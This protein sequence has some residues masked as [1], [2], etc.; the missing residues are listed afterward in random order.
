[1]VEEMY[2]NL[3]SIRYIF[4][5]DSQDFIVSAFPEYSIFIKNFI[6]NDQILRS[7]KVANYVFNIPYVSYSVFL[8]NQILTVIIPIINHGLKLGTIH[9]GITASLNI[10]FMFKLIQY[11]SL[12][13]FLSVWGTVII[14]M[15]FIIISL[16]K[17]FY[18]LWIGM[19]N[20]G[21]GN[22]AQRIHAPVQGYFADL[23]IGF[24]EMAEKLEFYEKKNIEQLILEK[25]KL[26]TLISI[27]ADGAIL[28]D[29][30]LRIIFINQSA[31]KTLELVKHGIVGTYIYDH[32]PHYINEQF[33]PVLNQM[34]EK[35]NVYRSFA[36]TQCLLLKFNNQVSKT[37]R[38][39]LTT[40]FDKKLVLTG[41]AVIIEDI[42]SEIVLNEAKA[43]FISNVSHELRTPLFNIKSF[44][45]TL[46]EYN[47]YLSDIQKKD[48]LEI[49]SQETQRLT[50]LVND[51]L[52]LSRLESDFQYVSD[53][54]LLTDMIPSIIQISQLRAKK[55]QIVLS[56]KICS[57]IVKV[58]AYH[59]L[60]MQVLSNLL[61]N[62][63]KF[64]Y[65]GGR[66]II[67][68]HKI[69]TSTI[70]SDNY[71]IDKV[72][73]QIID[74]GTGI[75]KNDQS[76]I[77]DRFV[78]LENNIHTL[79]GTGLGLSIVKNIVEKHNSK[80]LLYSELGVGSSFWFDL[81]LLE[82]NN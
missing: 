21:K 43:Q 66:I 13:V 50:D 28:L 65:A 36:K 67:K 27:I 55:K 3:F 15:L 17:P 14:S 41:I 58:D 18:N 82:K 37:L 75:R 46:Y 25:S 45:E 51:V 39:V 52:D 63:L 56:Y 73:I 64:I 26:E 16:I 69:T 10:F 12:A 44:L 48:F 76:R 78:R 59:N 68:A 40:V 20:I 47:D 49:A 57:T 62:A 24:N 53:F 6:L 11:V 79:E 74:E 70:N 19:Q 22:F 33:L 35:N 4:L 54:V 72:R 8:N 29:P 71:P 38:F 77:F 81:F 42:T 32:F 2:L 60:L 80:V 61:D 34:I 5:F 30:E 1:M 7:T 23:I 9:L 31:S